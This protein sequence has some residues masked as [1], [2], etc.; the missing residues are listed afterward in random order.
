MTSETPLD[1]AVTR[2]VSFERRQKITIAVVLAA[3]V[4][5]LGL[6]QY[7][8]QN[9][10]TDAGDCLTESGPNSL[11]QVGCDSPEA[12]YRVVGTVEDKGRSEATFSTCGRFK[13]TTD[14]Y[15]QESESVV[16]CLAAAS[17]T[18]R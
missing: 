17:T 2:R 12:R 1:S 10:S 4:V 3:I 18:A 11:Q 16:L 15:W 6:M 13:E 9:N 7:L 5:V 14:I 8:V